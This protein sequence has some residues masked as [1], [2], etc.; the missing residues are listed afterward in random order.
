M[1]STLVTCQVGGGFATSPARAGTDRAGA[2]SARASKQAATFRTGIEEWGMGGP[3]ERSDEMTKMP[4]FPG[5]RLILSER[6]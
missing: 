4:C 2:A 1:S 3:L 5:I 6:S